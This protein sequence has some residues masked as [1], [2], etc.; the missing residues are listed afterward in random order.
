MPILD[1][2]PDAT[3]SVW[4]NEGEIVVVDLEYTAW[5]QSLSRGWGEPWE[6]REIVHVGALLVEA[7]GFAHMEAYEAFVK[8]IRNPLLSD[9]FQTLTG[10]RQS[11]VDE[12]GLDFQQ[13]IIELGDFFDK[14]DIAI[15]NG[16]DGEVLA[17]NCA[18][19][20]IDAPF[21]RPKMFNFRPLLS[22]SLGCSSSELTSSGLPSLAGIKLDLRKHS[23]LDDC[24]AIAASLAHWRS[25]GL[26]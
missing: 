19:H 24:F 15:F 8:P 21:I 1:I 22:T 2:A 16:S 11:D 13:M 25:V 10:I 3:L 18:F 6:W 23:A 26:V 14:G 12:H 7:R 4:P 17:E 9:Y 20:H 5:E